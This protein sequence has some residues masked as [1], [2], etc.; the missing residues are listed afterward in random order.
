MSLNLSDNAQS[1][2]A[3]PQW[4]RCRRGPV[5]SPGANSPQFEFHSIRLAVGQLDSGG[6]MALQAVGGLA[7]S[8]C[9][10]SVDRLGLPCGVGHAQGIFLICHY[11]S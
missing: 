4:D 1:K 9:G 6:C 8:H 5:Q 3:L 7:A 2:S 10:V 11:V